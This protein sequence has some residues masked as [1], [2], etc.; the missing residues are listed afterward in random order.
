MYSINVLMI[1]YKQEKLVSRALES[2]ICQ[3]NYGLKNI[4][5]SDDCSPDG[6]WDVLQ[7][8]A[9]KYPDIIK[10]FRNERNLGIY[11]NWEKMISIRGDADLYCVCVGD[12]A[13][14]DGWFKSV[15]ENLAKRAIDLNGVAAS[16]SSDHKTIRPNGTYIINRNNR[17]IEKG[18]DCIS[19]KARNIINTRSTMATAETYNRYKPIDHSQGAVYAEELADMR[20]YKDSDVHYYVPFVA[21]VYYTHIGVSTKLTTKEYYEDHKHACELYKKNFPL[22]KKASLWKDFQ[23]DMF[24]YQIAPSFRGFGKMLSSYY[25][26]FDR[27]TLYGTNKLIHLLMWGRLLKKLFI[28]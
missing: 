25:K 18:I 28:R 11:G 4:I 5:I 17:L 26:A 13:L 6:T 24:D 9:K 8:Y 23:I 21:T 27:Y 22:D 7:E 20:V 1:T 19:M 2:I 3:K 12:D 16:I 10:P 15:Q 14:C